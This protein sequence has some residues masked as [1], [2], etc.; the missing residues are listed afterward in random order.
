M[1]EDFKYLSDEEE[2]SS[3][4]LFADLTSNLDEDEES[5]NPELAYLA[6]LRQVRDND[7]KLFSLVKKLP[8]KA[9]AGK[10]SVKVMADTTV[11]F[12]RQGALKTFFRSDEK[13]TEQLS[14]MQA[15]D[16]IKAEPQDPKTSITSNFYGQFNKNSLAFDEMLVA[17]EVATTEKAI[18]TGNDAKIIKL[19]KAMK[20]EPRFTDKEEKI[21]ERMIELWNNGEM[22]AKVSKDV[23][24]K[25][26][27]VAD[28]LEL[29]HELLKL[30]P[31]TYFEEQRKQSA[32]VDGEKQ[33]VL[34]CYLTVGGK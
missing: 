29:Y 18:V 34:S 33:I 25:T 3:Q 8:K 15:I 30:I 21:I 20:A 4:K 23:M 27:L 5:T 10:A 31:P 6:I 2:V 13:C 9:K 28:V 7:S 26:K 32:Q 1:P 22:P 16:Y 24:K 14:F 19:L 12:I 17:D 11:T